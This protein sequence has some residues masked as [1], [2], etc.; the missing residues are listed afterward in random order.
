[1]AILPHVSP[2]T[3]IILRAD[4]LSGVQEPV[5]YSIGQLSERLKYWQK[6]LRLQDWDVSLQMLRSRDMSVDDALGECHTFSDQKKAAIRILDPIDYEEVDEGMVRCLD[7]EYVL[8]HELCHLYFATKAIYDCQKAVADDL[9]LAVHLFAETLVRKDRESTFY[10]NQLGSLGEESHEV[11]ICCR[12]P[13]VEDDA[14]IAGDDCCRGG[15]CVSGDDHLDGSRDRD[16]C[17]TPGY[18]CAGC[19]CQ[20]VPATLSAAEFLAAGLTPPVP[21]SPLADFDTYK[22]IMARK[23]PKC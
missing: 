22:R 7:H 16:L 12:L 13:Q 8:V 21:E 5:H 18:V 17:G 11:D 4:N 15:E 10:R 6:E 1:M 14:N 23:A 19:D 2:S 3:G 20:T 9:E